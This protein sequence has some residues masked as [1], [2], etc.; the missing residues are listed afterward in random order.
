MFEDLVINVIGF[1]QSRLQLYYKRVE[2]KYV[3]PCFD[4]TVFGI[5]ALD[6]VQFPLTPRS[7]SNASCIN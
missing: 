7:P 3:F 5:Y 6:K 1:N 2:R 4:V